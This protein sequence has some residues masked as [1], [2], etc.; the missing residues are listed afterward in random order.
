MNFIPLLLI[1]IFFQPTYAAVD[2]EKSDL[3]SSESQ[4]WRDIKTSVS[5]V[6]RGSVAQFQNPTNLYYLPPAIGATWYSFKHDDRISEL[7]QNK[8][9]RSHIKTIGDLGIVL[10]FP[11]LSGGFYALGRSQDNRHLQQFAMEYFATMY[12]VL[13]ESALL[14]LVPIHE[15]PVPPEDLNF[16]EKTFRGDSSFPSGHVVPYTTL[17]FKTLQFYGPKIA[18]VPFIL[19]VI[20]SQQRVRDGKHYMSDVVGSFFLSAFASEG[21]RYASNYHDNHPFYRR[22]LDHNVQLGIMRY[23]NALGPRISWNF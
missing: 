12:L 18:T 11:F 9:M 8:K 14:S 1:F 7:K 23:Q 5:L 3:A 15:R 20:A 2:G 16:W 22:Y 21:V 10:S 4:T 6:F 19:T 13:G 17:F